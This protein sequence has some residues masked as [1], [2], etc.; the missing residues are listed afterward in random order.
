MFLALPASCVDWANFEV[1]AVW[2]WGL[3]FVDV[4]CEGT[5]MGVGR[6][7]GGHYKCQNGEC[8]NAINRSIDTYPTV[9][10]I[11]MEGGPRR[12]VF[13]EPYNMVFQEFESVEQGKWRGRHFIP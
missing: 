8:Q 12:I 10:L 3:L 2:S 9:R 11:E 5:M 7:G 13:L 1:A 4:R 6:G